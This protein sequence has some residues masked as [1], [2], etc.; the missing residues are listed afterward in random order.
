MLE[1]KVDKMIELLEAILNRLN[2]HYPYQPC[3][4][5]WEYRPYEYLYG[6]TMDGATH[7]DTTTDT[8][9]R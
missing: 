3:Y 8:Y 1:E 7:T 6:T 2:Y 4:P 9:A 5:C